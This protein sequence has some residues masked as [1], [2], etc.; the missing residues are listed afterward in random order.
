MK[1]LDRVLTLRH[2]GSIHRISDGQ[3]EDPIG[4]IWGINQQ[5]TEQ[6]EEET[7]E[8]GEGVLCKTMSPGSR[9]HA[10]EEF[11]VH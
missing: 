10:T 6:T 9:G 3:I 4:H 7:S 2:F 11:D 8:G 1:N 5:L